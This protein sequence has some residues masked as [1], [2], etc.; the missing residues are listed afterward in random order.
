MGAAHVIVK[1]GHA[2]GADVV[3]LVFDGHAFDEL[4]VPRAARRQTRGTGCSYASA[5]AAFLA[6]GRS[7]I[8]A[9]SQAQQHVAGLIGASGDVY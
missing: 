4:R 6:K 1:G 8:E 9:A 7:L 5:V 2:D 3:D